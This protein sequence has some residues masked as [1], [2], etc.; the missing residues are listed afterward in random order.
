LAR[1][2]GN[3]SAELTALGRLGTCHRLLG[4]LNEA[5]SYG[6]AG[7]QLAGQLGSPY[8]EAT[9]LHDLG[10]VARLD[11]EAESAV[12]FYRRAVEILDRLQA[13]AL[14]AGVLPEFAEL[15]EELRDADGLW[16]TAVVGCRAIAE[17][18]EEIWWSLLGVVV[19]ALRV[20]L[21]VGGP[22]PGL[23][24]FAAQVFSIERELAPPQLQ[25]LRDLTELIIGCLTCEDAEI[26][27]GAAKALD[28]RTDGELGIYEF[29]EILQVLHREES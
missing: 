26:L 23:Q 20:G 22:E 8:A 1:Q 10:A 6:V 5:L 18:D 9:F 4:N 15:C 29:I 7:L 21:F 11:G 14:C 27:L 25:F 13:W 2:D 3:E 19:N 16:M 24:E 12:D 17:V 28:D